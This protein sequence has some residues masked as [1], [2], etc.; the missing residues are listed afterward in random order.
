MTT[1][2]IR[3]L[4]PS[5]QSRLDRRAAAHGRSAEAEARD[6]L[7]TTLAN[8]VPLDAKPDF[9][10]AMRAIVEG[11]GGVDLDLPPRDLTRDPPV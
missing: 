10:V 5:I 4:D 1:L 9:Y 8:D 7:A 6:I 3:D 11:N 2:T